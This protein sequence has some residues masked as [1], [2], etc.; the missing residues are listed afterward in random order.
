MNIQTVLNIYKIPFNREPQERQHFRKMDREK[1]FNVL[2]SFC[3]CAQIRW[4]NQTFLP[5]LSARNRFLCHSAFEISVQERIIT[6][7]SYVN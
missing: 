5:N 1:L 6:S 3:M 4:E 7:T 2:F